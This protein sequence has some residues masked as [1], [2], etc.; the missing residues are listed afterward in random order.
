MN[1]RKRKMVILHLI[2]S[3]KYRKLFIIYQQLLNLSY[4]ILQFILCYIYTFICATYNIIHS[5]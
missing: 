5:L 2:T 4:L 3:E 1:Y